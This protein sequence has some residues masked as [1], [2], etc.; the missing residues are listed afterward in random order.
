MITLSTISFSSC[1]NIMVDGLTIASTQWGNL[2]ITFSPFG[3]WFWIIFWHLC[4]CWKPIHFRSFF[5]SF[6]KNSRSFSS[7]ISRPDNNTSKIY[8]KK[9][10]EMGHYDN[11]GVSPSSSINNLV[12]KL[13][14]KC[15]WINPTHSGLDYT[16]SCPHR[17]SVHVSLRLSVVV[18]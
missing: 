6:S 2:T 3:E 18:N 5:S 7:C 4:C 16:F 9:E 13:I 12:V 11:V 10:K 17:G 8:V 15:V 1:E 14:V